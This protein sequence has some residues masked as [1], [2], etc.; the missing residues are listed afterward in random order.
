MAARHPA[1]FVPAAWDP[2]CGV[3]NRQL[4][5]A[6]AW[7]RQQSPANHFGSAGPRPERYSRRLTTPVP[8]AAIGAAAPTSRS[9]FRL[10]VRAIGATNRE[11]DT[12][13]HALL[14]K[15]SELAGAD[16]LG[17][18]LESLDYSDPDG[19][20]GVDSRIAVWFSYADPVDGHLVTEDD[21]VL[22]GLSDELRTRLSTPLDS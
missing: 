16:E 14:A 10:L 17:D 22:V 18:R 2:R 11:A 8:P 21:P 9:T 12:L 13:R 4:V 1:H 6:G 7:G 20:L 19:D 15:W 3:Y 5:R